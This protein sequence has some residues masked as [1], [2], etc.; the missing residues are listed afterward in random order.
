LRLVA[1]GLTNR[2]IARGLALSVHTVEC[3]A[4]NIYRKLAVRTRAG[5]AYSARELGLLN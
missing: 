3:H 2:E 4:K 5:A 1:Q